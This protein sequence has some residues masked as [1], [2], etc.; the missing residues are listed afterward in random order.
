MSN[1]YVGEDDELVSNSSA[2]I[3]VCLCVDTSSSMNLVLK[4]GTMTGRTFYKDGQTWNEVAGD[5]TT[6]LDEMVSGIGKFYETIKENPQAKASC[7]ICVVTYDDSARVLEDFGSIEGRDVPNF[8]LGDNTAMSEG[9]ELALKKLDERKQE[10]K[11]NGVEYYQPWL[12]LFTDGEPTDDV[13]NVQSRT[14]QMESANK[15]TIFPIALTDDADKTALAGFSAKR[16]PISIKKDK[17]DKFFE[18]LGKS[19]ATVSQSQVGDKVKLDTS[20]IDDWGS[21]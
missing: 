20:S 13:E 1:Q 8:E 16:R 4:G 6:L 15:L 12:V 7:E 19:V 2:R 14:K 3:P 9:V 11:K 17:L 5:V 18:W 10:Y 21:I